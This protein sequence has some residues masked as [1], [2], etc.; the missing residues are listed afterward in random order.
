MTIALYRDESE[1]NLRHM[2]KKRF[3]VDASGLSNVTSEILV[4]SRT[5]RA[6][7]RDGHQFEPPPLRHQPPKTGAFAFL[8]H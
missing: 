7:S 1:R 8:R 6:S 5:R 2:G 3:I 4:K